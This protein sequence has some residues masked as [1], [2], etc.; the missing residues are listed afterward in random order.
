VACLQKHY[1]YGCQ[2]NQHGFDIVFGKVVCETG[3]TFSR[4]RLQCFRGALMSG[5]NRFEDEP[6]GERT[7]ANHIVKPASI[8]SIQ[9]LASER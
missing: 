3:Q 1:P 2:V 7:I 8:E 4:D 9:K 6:C 5:K